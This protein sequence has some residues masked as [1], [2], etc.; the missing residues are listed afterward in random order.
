M[1]NQ[2][3]V[4]PLGGQSPLQGLGMLSAGLEQKRAT[5]EAEAEKMRRAELI[6]QA[7]RVMS[8]GDPAAIA[9][10]S[11]ANPELGRQLQQAVGYKNE[12]TRENMRS[13]MREIIAGA[14]PEEVITRRIDMVTNQGGDP[15]DSVRELEI[16]RADP[17]GYKAKVEAAYAFEDPEGYKSYRTTIPEQMTEYQT[18]D[19]ELKTIN[20]GIRQQEAA[21]RRLEQQIKREGDDIK[22]EELELKVQERKDKLNALNKDRDIA[23]TEREVVGENAITG[24][25]RSL[26]VI[27]E[28]YNHPSLDAAVGVKGPSAYLPGTDTQEV[29]SLIETLQS[30]SFLN[31]VEKMKG[32]G[33]L[34]EREG[35]ALTT[36][37]G[38]LNRDM[39]EK[40]F[41]RS[42][43]RIRGYFEQ[44][45][46]N[47]KKK[48][49]V[50]S[51]TETPAET[52]V[53]TVDW[54]DL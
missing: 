11:L 42:L 7:Q 36:A 29:I 34:T 52:T 12:A 6:T 14:D 54:S 40:A 26:G 3:S 31:E 20:T 44:A 27:D 21:L 24:F 30:Q 18:K 39:S 46:E 15:S 43:D 10:F 49:S 33:A 19:L 45:K 4:T 38:S 22:R 8:G 48:Y 41:K 35:A 23:Q 17:E 50:S 13:S 1:A 5:E 51:A 32:L 16:Y 37:V 9:E 53:T 47:T 28:I 2:F 25:D